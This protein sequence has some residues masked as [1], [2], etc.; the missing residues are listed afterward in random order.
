MQDSKCPREG[1]DARLKMGWR[2]GK[3][4][5]EEGEKSK[6]MLKKKKANKRQTTIASDQNNKNNKN[7]SLQ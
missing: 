6:G 3:T 1:Q 7:N 5:K 2:Q 4:E